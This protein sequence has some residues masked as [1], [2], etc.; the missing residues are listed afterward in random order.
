MGRVYSEA[1]SPPFPVAANRTCYTCSWLLVLLVLLLPLLRSI[2][3]FRR[4][5]DL[6]LLAGPLPPQ[7]P[8][9][10]LPAC[11]PACLVHSLVGSFQ[12]RRA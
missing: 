2:T 8:L 5:H 6:V 7:I 1:T 4:G 10:L 11:L 3:R 9:L 12:G